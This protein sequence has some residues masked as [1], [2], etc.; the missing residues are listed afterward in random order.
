MTVLNQQ[1]CFLHMSAMGSGGGRWTAPFV[2]VMLEPCPD[3][4]EEPVQEGS[5]QEDPEAGFH[6]AHGVGMS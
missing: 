6:L 3:L 5:G 2:E 1:G 4:Q